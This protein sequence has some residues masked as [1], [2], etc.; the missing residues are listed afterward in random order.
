MTT[1][2]GFE[3]RRVTA[4]PRVEATKDIAMAMVRVEVA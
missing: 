2:A 1:E 3:H 4:T